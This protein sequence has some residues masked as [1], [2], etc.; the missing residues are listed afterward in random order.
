MVRTIAMIPAT[1]CGMPIRM[2]PSFTFPP[3]AEPGSV[4][5]VAEKNQK[6]V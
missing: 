5:K 4:T 3:S 2:L 6:T 1:S